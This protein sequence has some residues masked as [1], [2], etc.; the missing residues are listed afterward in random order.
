MASTATDIRAV[1]SK[2]DWFKGVVEI[3]L[4]NG[5]L[6]VL[7]VKDAVVVA[8][9]VRTSKESIACHHIKYKRRNVLGYKR[10]PGDSTYIPICVELI[11]ANSTGNTINEVSIK[12]NTVLSNAIADVLCMLDTATAHATGLPGPVNL[13]YVQT[14]SFRHVAIVKFM[15]NALPKTMFAAAGVYLCVFISKSLH[16]IVSSFLNDNRF[17]VPYVS[18]EWY[19][20]LDVTKT[21]NSGRPVVLMMGL[22]MEISDSKGMIGMDNM[23]VSA[24]VEMVDPSVSMSVAELVMKREMVMKIVLLS[25]LHASVVGVG[26]V[27]WSVASIKSLPVHRQ[28]MEAA[29]SMGRLRTYRIRLIDVS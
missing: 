16:M 17:V 28:P 15:F 14:N 26:N 7:E 8:E 10:P 1:I 19:T 9:L 25:V 11:N 20:N 18:V 23:R 5:T 27:I 13:A 6:S 2:I 22:Y 29:Q 12:V 4:S 21:S 24:V 3:G